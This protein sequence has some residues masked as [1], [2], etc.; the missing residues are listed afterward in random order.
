MLTHKSNVFAS[1][2]H[3]FLC[4][5]CT[6]CV[7]CSHDGEVLSFCPHFIS[8]TTT[9]DMVKGKGKVSSTEHHAMKVY[10]GSGGIAPFIL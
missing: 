2:C 4:I 1:L 6:K 5:P 10:W 3:I 8:K 9:Q 7:Q